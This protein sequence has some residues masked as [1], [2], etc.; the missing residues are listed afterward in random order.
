MLKLFGTV[1]GMFTRSIVGKIILA[2]ISVFI[3]NLASKAAFK[4]LDKVCGGKQVKAAV[5]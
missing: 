2:M 1:I 3:G 5:I 4:S